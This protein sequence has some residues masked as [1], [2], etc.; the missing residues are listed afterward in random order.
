MLRER[1]LAQFGR[2][3]QVTSLTISGGDYDT[4]EY[5]GY[6]TEVADATTFS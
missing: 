4:V 2:P 1:K 3:E 5:A 6:G